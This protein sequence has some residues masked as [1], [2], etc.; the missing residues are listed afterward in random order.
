[1][2]EPTTTI[3]WCKS[4][5]GIVDRSQGRVITMTCCNL[6]ISETEEERA[7][8]LNTLMTTTPNM[9][10]SVNPLVLH[11]EQLAGQ[12]DS[13]TEPFYDYMVLDR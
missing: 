13:P 1:M 12:R 5:V 11:V 8:K 10:Y 2:Q 3:L 4:T 9:S 6:Q 7:C